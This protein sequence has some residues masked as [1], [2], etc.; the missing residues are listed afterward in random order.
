MT[1]IAGIAAEG[2]VYLSGDRGASDGDSILSMTT[3]KI[4]KV[5]DWVMGYAGS[6]GLGQIL[7][8]MECW[9]RHPK[10]AE[11]FLRNDFVEEY[12][13]LREKIGGKD[14]EEASLLI[15]YKG[16]LYEMETSDYGVYPFDYTAI[17]S[18][19]PIALGSLHASYTY[20]YTAEQ[21]TIL[22]VE[23][24]IAHS[25]TCLGPIDTLSS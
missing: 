2:V 14:E 11:R 6:G 9:N 3:P 15:G 20:G 25:P 17:G 23:S 19:G 5:N 18:G 12:K 24:A 22:A 13:A 21:R 4:I 7:K 1:V 16:I 10:N 8:H